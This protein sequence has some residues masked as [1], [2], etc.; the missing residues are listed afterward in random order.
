MASLVQV[1]FVTCKFVIVTICD[2]VA[3]CDC[4]YRNWWWVSQC[5]TESVE[6]RDNAEC[7]F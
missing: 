6:F 3:I 5:V 4:K 7:A 1:E 2:R